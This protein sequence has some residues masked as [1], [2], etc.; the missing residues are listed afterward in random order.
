MSRILNLAAVVSVAFAPLALADSHAT[1]AA[2]GVEVIEAVVAPTGDVAAGESAFRQCIACHVV[3]NAEGEVLAGRRAQTGPNLYEVSMRTAGSVEGYRYSSA[4][5]E[6]G[7]AGLIWDEANFVAYVQDPTGFLREYLD[8][9]GARSA[10][11]YRVRSEDDAA[12]LY[13][14][15]VSLEPA[16]E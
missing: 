16:V 3:T 7:E 12:N 6:A 2:D 14:Y 5:T 13:A 15:L 8:D 9:S 1:A 11:S 10:M 4:L